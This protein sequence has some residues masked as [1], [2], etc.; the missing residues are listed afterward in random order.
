MRTSLAAPPIFAITRKEP[1]HITLAADNGAVAHIFVL[2]DDIVRIAVLP[3]GGWR[4]RKT[5]AIAPGTDDVPLEG[6]E[7]LDLAGFSLPSYVC[8]E[9]DG[10]LVVETAQIRLSIALR[11]FFCSWETRQDGKWTKAARDR[12]TQAY[13]FGWWD[14]RVYHY[15][16]RDPPEK[17]FG[18]G[19]RSGDMD[20]A[21][22][23]F[24][25]TGVDAMGYSA[26]D[27]R[28]ALQAHSVLHH[29]HTGDGLRPFL[30]HAVGL[31]L[32][33]GLR[34][35]ELSR[36]L[37]KLRRRS[38]RSR[39][40]LHCGGRCGRREPPLHLADRPTGLPAAMEPR[41]FWLDHE[42][43]GCAGRADAHERVPRTLQGARHSLLFL[44][45]VV[46]LHVDRKQAL[47]L[48][49]EPREISR[50]DSVRHAFSRQGRAPRSQHQTVPLARPSAV[51]GS[52]SAGPLDKRR[53]RR[54]GVGA[55]L[56]RTRRLSRFHQSARDRVVE[57]ARG[58]I[59][60]GPRHGG[61]VERQQRVRDRIARLRVST[62]SARCARVRRQNRSSRS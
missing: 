58:R 20:R 13:N 41:L 7:R 15:L 14:D 52:T 61:N 45:S 54:T 51:C 50:S 60:P 10:R 16:A 49:L 33:H 38:R 29:L 18:L 3:S 6:R 30:R 62:A 19:E 55:I 5:W 37:S 35:I 32:R 46:G 36:S 28:S 21:G 56:G 4:L 31:H 17:Y 12:R 44:P 27:L 24:R 8:N 57:S 11:G 43:H 26:R 53:A 40:L 1:G 42:L 39:L 25:M 2:E 47:R 9:V 23:R 48:S 34:A 22:R 59:P